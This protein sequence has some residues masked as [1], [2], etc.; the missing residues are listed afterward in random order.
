MCSDGPSGSAEY[1]YGIESGYFDSHDVWQSA[2]VVSFR[3]TK[4]TPKRI[5]YLRLACGPHE[6]IGYVNR[7]KLEADGE[8]RCRSRCSGEPDSRL[9]LAP[10]TINQTPPDGDRS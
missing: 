10:P 9:Y 4:K 5:Y 7:R 3:I 6:E 1:L 8:I 2:Q